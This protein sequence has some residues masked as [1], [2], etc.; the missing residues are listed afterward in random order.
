[1]RNSEGKNSR[2]KTKKNC[3]DRWAFSAACVVL[4]LKDTQAVMHNSSPS[5]RSH[6]RRAA[7]QNNHGNLSMIHATWQLFIFMNHFYF[8]YIF[9]FVEYIFRT[10]GCLLNEVITLKMKIHSVFFRK[11]AFP[12]LPSCHSHKFWWRNSNEVFQVSNSTKSNIKGCAI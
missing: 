7:I 9:K 11:M 3:N 5:D 4:W 8:G 6:K 2:G 12:D 1:M 10:Q